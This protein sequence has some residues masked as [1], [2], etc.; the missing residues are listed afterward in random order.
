MPIRW[1]NTVETTR[2]WASTTG[3]PEFEPEWERFGR[4]RVA[5]GT[6]DR[7]ITYRDHV[8]PLALRVVEALAT[9]D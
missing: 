2:P 5:A 1:A 8:R 9:A 6:Y 7:P 4:K 3:P